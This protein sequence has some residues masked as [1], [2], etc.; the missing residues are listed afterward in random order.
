[1]GPQGL[2]TT[3]ESDLALTLSGGLSR[4]LSSG[5]INCCLLKRRPEPSAILQKVQMYD[6][7]M[8]PTNRRRQRQILVVERHTIIGSGV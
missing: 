2:M 4:Q 1:M 7:V 3:S 5:E 8:V 6:G